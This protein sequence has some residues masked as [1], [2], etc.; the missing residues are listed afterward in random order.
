MDALWKGPH[1][2]NPGEAIPGARFLWNGTAKPSRSGCYPARP[3]RRGT[4]SIP[5]GLAPLQ[6]R[7]PRKGKGRPQ[8]VSDRF[9]KGSPPSLPG[10]LGAESQSRRP[11]PPYLPDQAAL[12]EA[13]ST[14]TPGPIE[15]LSETFLT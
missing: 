10:A 13:R 3:K 8:R 2:F 7:H 4:P 5:C 12:S 11:E 14:F 6:G 1:R 9:G 15:E